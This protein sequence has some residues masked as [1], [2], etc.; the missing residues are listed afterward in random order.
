M[1]VS[2]KRD[3]FAAPPP[4]TTDLKLP[5]ARALAALMPD[6]VDTPQ[7]DWPTMTRAVLAV[8]MG[9]TD[10]SGTATRAI[11]G[12]RNMPGGP[13][14]PGLLA[15]EYIEEVVLDIDGVS[16]TNYQITTAGIRAYQAYVAQRGA[17]PA[18]KTSGQEC[19]NNRYKSS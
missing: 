1:P 19:T 15:M 9:Y 7:F 16:E 5:Q 14:F 12:G 6:R 3:P 13:R 10:M 18:V 2:P 17:L 4:E 11:N 8:R